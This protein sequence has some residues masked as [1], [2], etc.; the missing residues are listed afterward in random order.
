MSMSR[1]EEILRG[2]SEEAKA[3]VE[4]TLIWDMTTPW[5]VPWAH[6]E[7]LP[8]FHRSGFNLVSLSVNDFPGS[9]RDTVLYTAKVRA[10]IRKQSD[11]LTIVHDTDDILTAKK[12]R[13]LAV[14]FNHQETNQLER[15]VEM[16]EVYYELGVRHM[17]LAYNQKNFVGDGCSEKT[18]A[19]LS[20][21][22]VELIQ[23]MNRVGMLVDGSHSGRRTTLE[24][25]EVCKGPFIFSHC[26]AD[27]VYPHFRNITDEQIRACARSGGV[28]GVNGLG[29]YLFDPEAKSESMFRH[30]D[31]IANL[32][33]PQYVGLALDFVAD[34]R[35]FYASLRTN[36]AQWPMINGKP[37]VEAKFV[38]PEQIYELVDLMLQRAYPE[39]NIRGILGENFF[40]VAKQVWRSR[41]GS[42]AVH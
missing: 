1:R 33:G 30:I 9:I 21:F 31:Y 19:G 28:V 34:P 12:D 42:A 5:R 8:R 15:S 16:V 22:G 10:S 26:C 40:R 35:P 36:A 14:I 27:G 17:L 2:T 6:E 18:D 25:M 38:Q 7:T 32:V 13:R 41:S 23:E 24:A 4:D 20:R 39:E 29:M 3:L 37:H 11:F